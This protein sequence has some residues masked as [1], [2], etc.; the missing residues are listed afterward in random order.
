MS[1]AVVKRRSYRAI[2]PVCRKYSLWALFAICLRQLV[3]EN[4]TSSVVR[5]ATR[6]CAWRGCAACG[7]SEKISGPADIRPCCTICTAT[8]KRVETV[9]RIP[10]RDTYACHQERADDED[11]DTER[12]RLDATGL[13]LLAAPHRARSTRARTVR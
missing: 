2:E 1:R 8:T 13:P 9:T 6:H 7:H 4:R 11:K 10:Q 5:A 12:Q 3:A